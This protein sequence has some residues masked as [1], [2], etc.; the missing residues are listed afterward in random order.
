MNV[1]L[2]IYKRPELTEKVFARIAQARPQK[3]FL[4]ADGAK[5]EKEV[6]LCMRTRA[7]VEKVDWPCE[8]FK[9]Y[10][11][12]NMG[13]RRRTS[14]GVSWVFDHVE[15]AIIF[16]DDCVPD[17]SFFPFCSELLERYRSD[18]RVMHISGNNFQK[19]IRR[20]S[21]SYY[22]SAYA[23]SWGWATWRRAWKLYD[24]EMTFWPAF[25]RMRGL[26]QIFRRKKEI[27][28][29]E[30]WMEPEYN[31]MMAYTLWSEQGWAPWDCW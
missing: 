14:S 16:D 27:V 11:D 6:E 4:I 5:D 29:W 30:R 9:N 1:A 8:V 20:S 25:K 3:L 22:F 13:C 24:A 28:F 10:A 31:T 26:E 21:Y 19:G 12:K 2:I 7:M 23:H 18:T 17:L 15:E